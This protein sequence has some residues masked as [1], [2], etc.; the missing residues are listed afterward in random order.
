MK[1]TWPGLNKSGEQRRSVEEGR[2]VG[3]VRKVVAEDLMEKLARMTMREEVAAPNEN[4]CEDV[5]MEET[6]NMLVNPKMGVMQEKE[7]QIKIKGKSDD[8]A[9]KVGGNNGSDLREIAD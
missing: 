3:M 2:K 4:R 1:I 7:E 9:T 6:Q 5:R 8:V